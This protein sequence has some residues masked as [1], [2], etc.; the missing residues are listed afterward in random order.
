M[1]K[2]LYTHHKLAYAL[3][4][5]AAALIL[6]VGFTLAILLSDGTDM[7]LPAAISLFSSIAA[8]LAVEICFES[9]APLKYYTA[10]LKELTRLSHGRACYTPALSKKRSEVELTISERLEK[11]SHGRMISEGYDGFIGRW[12]GVASDS[13]KYAEHKKH[14]TNYYLYSVEHLDSKVMDG[15]EA[16]LAARLS[17]NRTEQLAENENYGIV[18]AVTVLADTV[19]PDVAQRASVTLSVRVS[20]TLVLR[21][22][23]LCIGEVSAD[24]YYLSAERDGDG[25]SRTNRSLSLLSRATF[26]VGAIRLAA[27]GTAHTEEYTRLLRDSIEKPLAE[28]ASEARK[29]ENDDNSDTDD[30]PFAGMCEGDIKRAL[31]VIYTVKN[32]I[33]V[34]GWLMTPEGAMDSFDEEGDIG[35]VEDIIAMED[36]DVKEVEPAFAEDYRGAV[37]LEISPFGMSGKRLRRV[38]R[39][40]RD[41][42]YETVKQYLISEGF[43]RVHKYDEK[44]KT[45]V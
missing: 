39:K 33:S 45:I 40:M 15:V 8:A 5:I 30:D 9:V 22:I 44:H 4:H 3:I 27:F 42:L 35:D 21:G 24:R 37:V 18:N 28:L 23:R 25:G 29:K 2:F 11:T 34:T 6:A 31:D 13:S 1:K 7:T 14:Y 16:D 26:G 12:R 36:D 19:D 20:D 43:E 32:G 41:E 38:S 10:R 17:A